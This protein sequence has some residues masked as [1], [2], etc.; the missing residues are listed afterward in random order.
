MLFKT[1]D[2]PAGWPGFAATLAMLIAGDLEAIG[3]YFDKAV[4]GASG[5]D[6]E[7]QFGIKCSD[8]AQGA[9]D[10]KEVLPIIEKRHAAS[11]VGGDAADHVTMRC[12]R[13]PLPAKERYEGDWNVKTKSPVLI[14]GNTYDPVSPLASAK[15]V[16]ATFE[17][18]VLLQQNSY[19][20]SPHHLLL[21]PLRLIANV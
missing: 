4:G 3:E 16:S 10:I 21:K 19:G 13:W 14:I 15:N 20:V 12:A 11:R 1:L 8:S 5:I 7:A 17:G 6:A 9:T 2:S 18:S